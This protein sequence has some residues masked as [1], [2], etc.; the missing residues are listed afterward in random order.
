DLS[1]APL[2]RVGLLT[3]NHGRQ[4]L[5]IDMHHIITDRISHNILEK[6]F[7][8]LYF[9]EELTP[10]RLQ[11]KDY[12]EWQNGKAHHQMI[13]EQEKYWLEIFSGEV[14]VLNLPFDYSRPIMQSFEGNMIQFSLAVKES[15]SIKNLAKE[16]GTTA[17]MFILSVLTILLSRLSGQE[18]IVIGTPIAARRHSDLEK[19]IGMFVNTLAMRNAPCGEKSYREFLME[20]KQCTLEAY[21][22]QEYPFEELVDNITVSRDIGRNP[23]FDIMFNLLN[24]QEYN[25]TIPDTGTEEYRS[26]HIQGIAKFDL[27]LTAV[28]M[29]ERLLFNI[30]YCTRLFKPETIDR[31]ISYFKKLLDSI[32][33][34]INK[35]LCTLDIITLEEKNRVLYEWN[36]TRG[37]YPKDK[38]INQIFEEQ[39]K[40]TPDHIAVIGPWEREKENSGIDNLGSTAIH[41]TYLHL[42]EQS[43]RLAHMLQTKGMGTDTIV[44]IMVERSIEMIVGILGIL[45]AG[46]AYLPIDPEYPQERIDYILRDSNAAILLKNTNKKEINCQLSIVNSQLSMCE[47][48]G[49]L[50]HPS[51]VHHYNHLAYI[52]YT[53]GSTGRPKG[54]MVQCRNVVRLVKNTNYIPFMAGKRLLQSGILAFDA[55]TFEIWGALLNGL[56]LCL[57][58]K[59]IILTADR[60]KEKI[61]KYDIE[62]MWMTSPLFNQLSQIDIDIFSNLKHL[63]VGGDVLSVIHMNRLKREFPDLKI[64]NGYGPTENTT[65]STTYLIE[66]EYDINIPIGK[67]IANSTAYIVDRNNFLQPIG[68][69][70]ELLV[71]GDGVALGYLNNPELTAKKFKKHRSYGSYR[72]NILYKT[73]D[74]ARWLPDGNIEFIGRIDQQ[75]KVRGFRIE[76]G[77]IET[78]L[79]KITGIKESVVI[80]REDEPGDKYLCAYIV[81]TKAYEII[82]L[83]EYLTKEL[84]AHMVPAYFVPVEK[85]PLTS[86]GK[87]DSKSLP[88][89]GLKGSE[90]YAAPRDAIEK[91]LTELW[92]DILVIRESAAARQS[93]LVEQIGID[94]NFFQLGG[95]SLKA[96]ILVSKIDKEFNVKVPLVKVFKSPTIRELSTYIKEKR[97]EGYKSIEPAEKKEFY[98]LASPQRVLYVQ[99]QKDLEST[100]YNM[101]QFFKIENAVNTDKTRLRDACKSMIQRHDSLRTSFEIKDGQ[102]VQIIHDTVEFDLEYY[103]GDMSE[104]LVLGNFVR[105]FDLTRA[106][107]LRVGLLKR[108]DQDY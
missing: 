43:N 47:L 99:Q 79:A 60:L 45:A 39:V 18:D 93:P 94:D 8:A 14:P 19:I 53:S 36:D 33:Q 104:T 97:N 40:L 92:T 102:P 59:E 21:E 90:E 52:I 3:V 85:I 64:T 65:F 7:R 74:L 24:I 16:T 75:V 73:G 98:L 105:P 61:K 56:T 84:P 32:F 42:N 55:S 9:K 63:V 57:V 31:F 82:E 71:G 28:D 62:I 83:R 25:D 76:L 66:K 1:K 34:D 91:K 48:R 49:S 4:I 17:Y 80:V 106:P 108:N 72:T 2:L 67:P 68:V 50:H 22:N 100:A 77:E 38:T 26:A 44:A 20:L 88:G 70:G 58:K 35:K 30:E 5:M 51:I 10:L 54:V 107:L 13:K 29:G 37:D 81:S 103:E 69:A 96:T 27:T 41:L 101:P 46:G 15:R 6:E 12:S 89:P 78:C 86:N 95:H 87:I 23:V 11:Y